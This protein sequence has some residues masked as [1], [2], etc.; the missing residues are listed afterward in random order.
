LLLEAEGEGEAYALRFTNDLDHINK[1]GT[2]EFRL[3]WLKLN[4]TDAIKDQF[5]IWG[6]NAVSPNNP[7]SL[8]VYYTIP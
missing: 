5:A 1:T 3:K 8:T 7:P 2:T 6:V 4:D